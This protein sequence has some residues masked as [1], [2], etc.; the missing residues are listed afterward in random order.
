MPILSLLYL[1]SFM[2]RGNIGNARIQ[3]LERDLNMNS[4]QYNL[5][6]SIYFVPYCLFEGEDWPQTSADGRSTRQSCP[7]KA[8]PFD[9]WV[10]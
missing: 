2:D 8:S 6:L 9:L 4:S 3:G 7:Q 5:A 10:S 1:L